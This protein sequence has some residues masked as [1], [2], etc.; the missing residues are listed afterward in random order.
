[1]YRPTFLRGRWR[2]ED[3]G[4]LTWN[5]H[6]FEDSG[7]VVVVQ[8]IARGIITTS[9]EVTEGLSDIA[10]ELEQSRL[11]G[12]RTQVIMSSHIEDI[13]I[14]LQG[15]CVELLELLVGGLDC[16]WRF[17]VGIWSVYTDHDALVTCIYIS[18]ALYM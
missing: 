7:S 17:S 15:C 1:M 14:V 16:R 8:K 10:R 9:Q 4:L 6:Y 5:G 18:R 11:P 13:R 3:D 12:L 2:G